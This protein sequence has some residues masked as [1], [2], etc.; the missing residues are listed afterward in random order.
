MHR[1]SELPSKVCLGCER[2]FAWRRKWV[3][4][5]HEIRFCSE[6]CR[7]EARRMRRAV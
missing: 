2:A 7:L 1:K 3:R 5:W 4:C 6:R